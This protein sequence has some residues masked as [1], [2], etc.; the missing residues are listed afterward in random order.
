[1]EIKVDI[2][3]LRQIAISTLHAKSSIEDA[4]KASN[5]VLQ[6]NEWNCKE[7]DLIDENII[8]IQ[9]S[10]LA[11]NESMILFSKK[12]NEIAEKFNEFDDMIMSQFSEFDASIGSLCEIEP[13]SITRVQSSVAQEC[14]AKIETNSYWERYH[15]TNIMQPISI[16]SFKDAT[17]FMKCDGGLPFSKS[18][19][20]LNN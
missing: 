10:N 6:H 3:T 15:S 7:R 17:S 1:M 18:A 14:T 13:A 12:V 19:D 11:I 20:T 8:A 16:V 9:K 2:D 4:I 5:F